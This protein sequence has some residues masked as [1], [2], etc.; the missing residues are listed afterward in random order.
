MGL[1]MGFSVISLAELLYFLILK[2]LVEL[3]VWKRTAHVAPERSLR[4]NPGIEQPDGIDNQSFWHVRELYPKGAAWEPNG[5]GR[6]LK[7]S[8]NIINSFVQ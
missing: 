1:F 7:R 8:R 5:K 6:K 3:F 4:Q 2:P